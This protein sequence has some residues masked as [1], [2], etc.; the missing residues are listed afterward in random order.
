MAKKVKNKPP[1]ALNFKDYIFIALM[2]ILALI[3]SVSIII[4]V[5]AFIKLLLRG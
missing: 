5:A 3:L 4:S 2:D 1:V